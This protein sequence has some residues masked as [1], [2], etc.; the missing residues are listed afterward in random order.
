[1]LEKKPTVREFFLVVWRHWGPLMSGVFSV[2]FAALSVF[3][4]SPTERPFGA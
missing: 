2:P 3:A 4:E 1:M